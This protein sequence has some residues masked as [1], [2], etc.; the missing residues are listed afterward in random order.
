MTDKLSAFVK[1][2]EQ[3]TDELVD[4]ILETIERLTVGNPRFTKKE[5][6]LY[7][8][9]FHVVIS[10]MASTVR[11]LQQANRL[12]LQDK[13]LNE[14]ADKAR[15]LHV[16]NDRAMLDVLRGLREMLRDNRKSDAIDLLT[17]IINYREE[18]KI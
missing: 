14:L 15:E 6:R 16:E 12:R 3:E 10:Q 7:G 4:G 8:R 17:K 2:T 1:A 13:E 18:G 5:R 11:M 9:F